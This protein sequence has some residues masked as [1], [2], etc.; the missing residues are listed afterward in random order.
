MA[1]YEFKRFDDGEPLD[2]SKLNSIVDNIQQLVS[3]TSPLRD[4]TD[5]SQG[6]SLVESGRVAIENVAADGSVS[7]AQ[8]NFTKIDPAACTA[9]KVN[10]TASLRNGLRVGEDISISVTDYASGNPKIHFKVSG[11]VKPRDTYYVTW[12]AV[13]NK[14]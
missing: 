6:Y 10:V 4:S 11:K 5:T 2:V 3:D 8:I 12:I 14:I 1:N 9:G 13:E 7:V